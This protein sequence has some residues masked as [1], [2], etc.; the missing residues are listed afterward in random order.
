MSHTRSAIL[1][2]VA[3]AA[4]AEDCRELYEQGCSVRSIA[5]RIGRSYG[6]TRQ[7]LVEAGTTF[8]AKNGTPRKATR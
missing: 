1:T 3:R 8:R 4:A 5:D 2:G 7:L 6:C